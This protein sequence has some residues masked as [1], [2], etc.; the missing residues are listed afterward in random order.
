MLR[1]P[2]VLVLLAGLGI[3]IL[4]LERIFDPQ[5]VWHGSVYADITYYGPL[6]AL[7]YFAVLL[8]TVLT[9]KGQGQSKLL[10]RC[11]FSVAI[12]GIAIAFIALRQGGHTSA[13]LLPIGFILQWMAL[14]IALVAAW[15]RRL[16]ERNP[17]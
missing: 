4:I 5:G 1:V 8:W 14:G 12:L 17:Q 9:V 3:E 16:H 11:A 15:R 2:T 6:S 13:G 10:L 7:P